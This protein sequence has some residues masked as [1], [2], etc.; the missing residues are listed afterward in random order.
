MLSVPRARDPLL[1]VVM[2]TYGGWDWPL[3]ALEALREH[4]DV[5]FEA[6][7]VDNASWDGTG[8]LLEELVGGPIVIRNAENRGFAAAANQGARVARGRVFCFLNPDC[9]VT[10]GWLVPLL[11]ALDRPRAGAA[12]PLFL[13]PDGLIDEAGSVV[14]CQGWT[15]AIGRGADPR[16][17]EHRFPR[18]IDYGSAACLVM[19]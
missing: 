19:R 14:D 5:P 17:P 13:D 2:V 6:I 8:D 16:E 11:R 9:L 4:T 15:E 18:V 7:C 12:I 1:S 10:P 3:R